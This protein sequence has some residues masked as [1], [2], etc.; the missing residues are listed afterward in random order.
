[1]EVTPIES[2]FWQNPSHHLPNRSFKDGRDNLDLWLC[3]QL[4]HQGGEHS[5][6]VHRP[7][8][9]HYCKCQQDLLHVAIDVEEG[10]KAAE[11]LERLPCD[12]EGSIQIPLLCPGQQ[13]QLLLSGKKQMALV[14]SAPNFN[15]SHKEVVRQGFV[16]IEI[17]VRRMVGSCILSNS[18]SGV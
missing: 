5:F 14:L 1:M 17:Q 9:G 3:V 10:M 18:V 16:Q 4:V 7:T 11:L 8:A 2:R 6:V 15:V 13:R 12:S